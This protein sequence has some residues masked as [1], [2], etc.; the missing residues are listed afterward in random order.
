LLVALRGGRTLDKAEALTVLKELFAACPEIGQACFVSIDPDRSSV[1]PK[2][3][4][5]IRLG[6]NFDSQHRDSIKKI[7]DT[8]KLELTEKEDMTIIHSQ[9]L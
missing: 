2:G 3:S 1:K 9:N 7:L 6:I 4:Y 8:H 5:K